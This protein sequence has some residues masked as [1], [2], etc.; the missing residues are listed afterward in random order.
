MFEKWDMKVYTGVNWLRIGSNGEFF[1]EKYD[2][3]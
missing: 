2:V 3:P 1:Y